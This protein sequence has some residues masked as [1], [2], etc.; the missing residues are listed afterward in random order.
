[1]C[2]TCGCSPCDK[3]GGKIENE[4]CAGCNMGSAECSC[5]AEMK[6]AGTEENAAEEEKA[7]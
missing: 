6:E 4:V 2:Q 3:C 7:E 5:E 1:M